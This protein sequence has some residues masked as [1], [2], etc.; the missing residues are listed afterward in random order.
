MARVSPKHPS[1]RTK[2]E[3]VRDLT[4]VLNA[5]V[6]LG[7]KIAVINNAAWVWTEFD[8]KYEGCRYWSALAMMARKADRN[9]KLIHEHV[10]PRD[11]IRKLLLELNPATDLKVSDVCNRF[12]I[13]VVVTEAEDSL[14]NALFSKTMPTEFWD[15]T[16]PSFQDPWLRYKRFPIIMVTDRDTLSG[17]SG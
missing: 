8:G 5:P 2:E 14:L 11:V 17:Q 16:H 10:V 15:A 4:Y 12:L 9:F 13:G 1:Y 7:T 3:I 6:S